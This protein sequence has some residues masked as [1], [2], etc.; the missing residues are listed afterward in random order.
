MS[1][2]TSNNKKIWIPRNILQF[3]DSKQISTFNKS[4]S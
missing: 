2:I 1:Y 4:Y 3:N